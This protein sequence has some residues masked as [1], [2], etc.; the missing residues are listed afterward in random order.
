HRSS[1]AALCE[2]RKIMTKPR[3]SQRAQ[4]MLRQLKLFTICRSRSA[5]HGRL[6]AAI[7]CAE[8]KTKDQ[9][10]ID[11]DFHRYAEGICFSSVFICGE[12][13]L[14]ALLGRTSRRFL[15]LLKFSAAK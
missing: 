4:M 13:L 2:R 15:L 3:P 5:L 12:I 14:F 9:S 11:T 6:S 8:K 1:V 10:Q 7:G